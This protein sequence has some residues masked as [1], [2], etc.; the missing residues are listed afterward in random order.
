M[1][2][3]LIAKPR[4]VPPIT[5]PRPENVE[6]E[7]LAAPLVDWI[8]KHHDPHT[9]VRVEWDHVYLWHGGASLPFPYTEV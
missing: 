3:K 4:D 9:E 8:R 1:N 2:E 5:S 6:L 7:A